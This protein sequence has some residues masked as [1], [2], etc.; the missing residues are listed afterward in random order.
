MTVWVDVAARARGLAS[1]LLSAPRLAELRGSHDLAALA[2]RLATL[3][4][5]PLPDESPDP[6]AM[7]AAERR[8]AGAQLRLLARWAG[9]RA[10][11]LAP[12][13]GEEDCRSIRAAIRGGPPGRAPAE[14][15]AGLVPTPTLPERALL[16]LLAARD[17]ATVA[18]LLVAWGNPHGPPL[19][20][21][22]RGRQPPLLALEHAVVATWAD[23]ARRAAARAG[24]AMRGYVARRID[25]ANCFSA[26][27]VAEHGGEG[28]PDAL[29][30]EGG[31]LLPLA[32]FRLAAGSRSRAA[33]A[34]F[35][36]ELVRRTP[37]AAATA[38]ERGAEERL[39][40]ALAREQHD[41]ARLDPAGPAAIIEFWLRLRGEV[42]ALQ[43]L[44]WALAAGAPEAHRALPLA[45]A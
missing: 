21:L 45:P 7:E 23:L 11:L 24:R 5:T 25:A 36:D 29:F 1:R 28:P 10:A 20:A 12:L 37:I 43:R 32:A 34:D 19:L 38:R 26:L 41:L 44:T 8:H 33:A 3:R 31:D 6:V 42:V 15:L 40:R 2:L 18:A 27:L 4:G 13:F 35:L 9:S 17:A 16:Q 14:R 22:A 30:L 39:A